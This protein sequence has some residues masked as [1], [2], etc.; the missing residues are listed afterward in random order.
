MEGKKKIAAITT[1]VI[2]VILI[3]FLVIMSLNISNDKVVKNTYIGNVEIGGLT[4]EQAKQEIQKNYKFQDIKLEYDGKEWYIAPS[5]IDIDFDLNKTVENAFNSNRK[6][7]YFTNLKNTI[8]YC[9]GSK[10]T[11]LAVISYDETKLKNEM[12]AISKDINREVENATINVNEQV[13]V[14]PEKNGRKLDIDKSIKTLKAQVGKGKF[15]DKLAVNE[16][17]AKVKKEDL[18]DINTTLSSYSTTFSTG[19]VNRSYNIAIASKS[20]NNI[21][22]KP[23]EEFSFNKTTG[24]RIKSNGYKSAPVIENGEMQLDYGGGVCQVSST[25]YNSV[26][27]SGLDIVHVK[28]H[29]IPSS[30][31]IKGRDATVAD[32]GIDLLFKNS[33]DHPVFIKSHVDGNTLYTE[34]YGNKADMKDVEITT[35]V[36]GVSPTGYKRVNDPSMPAGKEKIDKNGRNAYS[37]STYRI[38][39]DKD[40]KVI[41]KEKV[42]SSYYPKKEGVILVGTA[43]APENADNNTNEGESN[44][45]NPPSGG[46]SSSGGS[47][48][49]GS[50]AGSGSGSGV[51]DGSGSESGGSGGGTPEP[52][53]EGQ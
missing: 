13:T 10:N 19:Q 46:G 43:K 21:V 24:K 9:F 8:S 33:F 26:L 23:G 1:A 32:S 50:S 17:Q 7:G 40:G 4:K 5:Q 29:T 27:L 52:P 49:G 22:L 14:V 53:A 11:V 38:F 45:P 37:V 48:S 42:A 20:L 51:S 34:I 35:S 16:E 39:K 18:K 36:D 47:G 25:L 30:Y 15:E 3:V 6:D 31:V 2:G 28:N 12:N 41:K 44:T